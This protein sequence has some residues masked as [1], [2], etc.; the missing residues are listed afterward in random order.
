MIYHAI[1]SNSDVTVIIPTLN[2]VPDKTLEILKKWNTF[3]VSGGGFVENCNK[4]IKIVNTKYIFLMNDDIEPCFNSIDVMR[5]Y[6]EK[7]P[8][9]AIVGGAMYSPEGKPLSSCGKYPT[10]LNALSEFTHLT[11]F[12][13]FLHRGH[14]PYLKTREVDYVSGCAMMVR[15]ELMFDNTFEA[16]CEDMELCKRVKNFKVVHLPEAMFIH[17]ESQSYGDRKKQ[18][19]IE[20]TEKYLLKY[21]SKL[22]TKICMW[23]YK[24]RI[25]I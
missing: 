22:Y 25:N 18:L 14:L 8:L 9:V 3:I 23:L 24:N 12:F 10:L 13:K 5:K 20:S 7:N 6:L 4:G 2:G 11:H 1:I 16:Y 19:I 17:R 21:H 15:R